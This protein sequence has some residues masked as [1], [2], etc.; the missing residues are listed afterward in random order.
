MGELKLASLQARIRAYLPLL[1]LVGGLS[2]LA[3][4]LGGG[5]AYVD[6]PYAMTRAEAFVL[7]GAM[8]T[9]S[10]S[11]LYLPAP[12]LTMHVYNPLM[13]SIAGW[14]GGNGGPPSTLFA[15]R[16]A[17]VIAAMVLAALILAWTYRTT[18][19]RSIAML[20]A[21]LPFFYADI[22]LAD[23]FRLRPETPALLLSGAAVILVHWAP[24]T[25]MA[26]GFA[27][28]LCTISFMFKQ[29]F[30]AA[31]VAIALA[32]WMTDPSRGLIFAALFGVFV[33]A[34]VITCTAI[35]GMPYLENVFFAMAGNPWLVGD[36][37][38]HYGAG[39]FAKGAGLLIGA[40]VGAAMLRTNQQHR[41]LVSFFGVS[42]LWNLLSSMKVGSNFSYFAELALAST[43]VM[44]VALS[45]FVKHPHYRWPVIC[46]SLLVAHMAFQLTFAFDERKPAPYDTRSEDLRPLA[47]RYAAAPRTLVLHEKLAV[48]LGSP[49]GYD[50]YL[51][52][53]F[54]DQGKLKYEQVFASL[55]TGAIDTVVFAK[56][57]WT[58]ELE[59]RVLNDVQ[60]LGFEKAFET[61]TLVEYR[62]PDSQPPEG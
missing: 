5:L 53:I 23:F 30:I 54:I 15:G 27:A 43:F 40:A 9:A 44:A 60:R 39:L 34:A 33:A 4:T 7:D 22:A 25:T 31:P 36:A 47:E 24:R 52:E 42:L 18:G 51:T 37:L 1:A 17:S 14:L 10:G 12:N 55:L 13:Y 21:T 35:W 59:D 56:A 49:F 57:I 45:E 6:L 29:S 41:V 8:R 50:W 20:A 58:H 38:T 28:A 48:Q 62:R 11:P 3:L 26:L 46:A 61:E 16:V 32:L 19:R 2:P